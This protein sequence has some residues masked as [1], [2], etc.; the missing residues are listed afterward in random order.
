MKITIPFVPIELE[1]TARRRTGAFRIPVKTALIIVAVIAAITHLCLPFSATDREL[2]ARYE[3]LANN[4]PKPDLTKDEVT[5]QI[6]TPSAVGTPVR[7]SC[8]DYKWV[9]HFDRP[10]NHQVFELSLAIDPHSDLVAGW[11]LNKTEFQ[12]IELAWYRLE[13]LIEWIGF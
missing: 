3:R 5:R 4:E 7:N 1:I 10:L 9:A 8:V 11:M 12:G 13:R 2:M 6:G